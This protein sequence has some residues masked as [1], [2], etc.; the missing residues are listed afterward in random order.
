MNFTKLIKMSLENNNWNNKDK[1]NIMKNKKKNIKDVILNSAISMC[2]H[3]LA[4]KLLATTWWGS[5]LLFVWEQKAWTMFPFSNKLIEFT[6]SVFYIETKEE[7]I[8][9]QVIENVSEV[10]NP[11][12]YIP[13]VTATLPLIISDN[14]EEGIKRVI[15]E[16]IQNLPSILGENESINYLGYIGSG[17]AYITIGGILFL[18]MGPAAT[19]GAASGLVV[20]KATATAL[21]AAAIK[22]TI[23]V[24]TIPKVCG[25]ITALYTGYKINNY[26]K[27]NGEVEHENDGT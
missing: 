25:I 16:N 23:I 24:S 12:S 3:Y 22:N 11:I 9:Q 10:V 14:M 8:T 18:I 1:K 6:R 5:V 21:T 2:G 19:I 26:I 7:I 4:K 13:E 20:T 27:D 17:A 15:T